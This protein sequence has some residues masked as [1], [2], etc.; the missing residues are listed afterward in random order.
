MKRLDSKEGKTL[1][2]FLPFYSVDTREE[3]DRLVEFALETGEFYRQADGSIL[4][5][6][7]Y[8]EQSIENLRLAGERLGELHRQIVQEE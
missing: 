5:M 6:T 3:A 1:R 8:R 7:L 4:E 2:G